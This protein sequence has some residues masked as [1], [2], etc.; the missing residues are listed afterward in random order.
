MVIFTRRPFPLTLLCN[1]K[2]LKVYNP[3][4]LSFVILL[5]VSSRKET[6]TYLR[7]SLTSERLRCRPSQKPHILPC[8][9][10]FFAAPRL[11]LG[12]DPYF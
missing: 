4:T 11:A 8:M 7:N 9:L 12:R 5:I 2:R 1:A 3:K 10:R 6:R